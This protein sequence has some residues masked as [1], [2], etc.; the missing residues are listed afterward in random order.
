MKNAIPS[1]RFSRRKCELA[2]IKL[3]EIISNV[4]IGPFVCPNLYVTISCWKIISIDISYKNCREMS[5]LVLSRVWKNIEMINWRLH[6]RCDAQDENVNWR[7][8]NFTFYHFSTLIVS[9]WIWLRIYQ[10]VFVCVHY[11]FAYT[12]NETRMEETLIITNNI[13]DSAFKRSL[14]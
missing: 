6:S 13:N 7:T 1:L 8:L 9:F 14:F 12:K 4:L 10:Q 3:H 5:L 2:I 11:N